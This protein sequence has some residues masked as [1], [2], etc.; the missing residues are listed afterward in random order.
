MYQVFL[1]SVIT[2]AVDPDG[3]LMELG[4][5]FQR[6]M[7]SMTR[8]SHLRQVSIGRL[9]TDLSNPKKKQNLLKSIVTLLMK[10]LKCQIV[11]T[12]NGQMLEPILQ[13]EAWFNQQD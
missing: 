5:D 4:Y 13:N 8:L 3:D 7:A 9:L 6:R 12:A 11:S 2:P 1:K 10:D